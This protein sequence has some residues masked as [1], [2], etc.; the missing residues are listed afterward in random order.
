M[1][2]MPSLSLPRVT[3]PV[4]LVTPLHFT[5]VLI[6]EGNNLLAKEAARCLAHEVMV[7]VE[8]SASASVSQLAGHGW[9]GSQSPLASHAAQRKRCSVYSKT[10]ETKMRWT[11]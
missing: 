1:F 3:W 4:C 10:H 11:E 6:V 9:L 7:F 2:R 5:N 8:E